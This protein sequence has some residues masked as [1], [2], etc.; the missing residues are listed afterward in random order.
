MV[1]YF[2]LFIYSVNI[3][4]PRHRFGFSLAW[5]WQ[6]AECRVLTCRHVAFL[7]VLQLIKSVCLFVLFLYVLLLNLY[8][9]YPTPCRQAF[10]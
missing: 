8:E 2:L 7:E 1:D 5:G 6:Y 10:V 9:H 3:K 4:P